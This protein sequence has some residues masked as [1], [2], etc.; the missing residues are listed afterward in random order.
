MQ[1]FLVSTQQQWVG[2]V[3]QGP[4]ISLPTITNSWAS[5]SNLFIDMQFP[6]T[7]FD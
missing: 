5:V 7:D 1:L 2:G 6:D 3:G 4:N